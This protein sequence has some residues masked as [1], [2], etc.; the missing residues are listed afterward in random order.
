MFGTDFVRSFNTTISKLPFNSICCPKT[1]SEIIESEMIYDKMK[2]VSNICATNTHKNWFRC[3]AQ[4]IK[5][6]Q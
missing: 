3:V 5:F 4:I 2:S 6:D 1:V